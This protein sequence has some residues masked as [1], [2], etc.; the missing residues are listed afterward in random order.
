VA[1]SVPDRERLDW[2]LIVLDASRATQL[3][4]HVKLRRGDR[5]LRV[6][7]AMTAV[8]A[9]GFT[10]ILERNSPFHFYS[11]FDFN[12]TWHVLATF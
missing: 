4:R 10:V 3:G 9:W 7:E 5:I 11:R 6:E 2:E 8:G 1:L 12:R